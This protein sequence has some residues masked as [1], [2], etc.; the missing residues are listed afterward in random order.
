MFHIGARTHLKTQGAV[1][2]ARVDG[3]TVALK[4]RIDD[5]DVLI[6]LCGLSGIRE[7]LGA[8]ISIFGR[9]TF[10][11]QDSF[12]FR[13]AGKCTLVAVTH[14]SLFGHFHFYPARPIGS[15][16]YIRPSDTE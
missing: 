11:N 6:A 13:H 8:A 16:H 9:H 15:S 7:G 2:A 4:S 14:V 12:R 1:I 10:P 5:G 3:T